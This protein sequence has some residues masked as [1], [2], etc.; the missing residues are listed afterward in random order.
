MDSNDFSTIWTR[1]H[2]ELEA[3]Q[4][5]LCAEIEA[6]WN[7]LHSILQKQV[8]KI[9]GL[10]WDNS[11]EG[12][13]S[14][15]QRLAK[16]QGSTFLLEPLHSLKKSRPLE[17]V[18]SAIDEY[19]SGIEDILRILPNSVAVSRKDRRSCLDWEGKPLR[20]F[21]LR[22]G[23]KSI[24]FNLRAIVSQALLEHS[25]RRAKCDGQ[26]Q[27][28][29]SRTALCL[30]IPWQF[31]RNEELNYLSHNSSTRHVIPDADKEWLRSV[32]AF[33]V[34]GSRRLAAYSRWKEALPGLLA[35]ALIA[36]DRGISTKHSNHLRERWQKHFRF[37][38][39]QQRAIVAQFEM[40]SSCV[41]L[42][43]KATDIS[44]DALASVDEEHTQLLLELDKVSQWLENWPLNHA[45]APFPPPEVRLVSAQDRVGEW[46]RRLE[47][48]GRRAL[49]ISIEAID[50]KR[51]LPGRRTRSRSIAAEIRFIKSL[52]DIGRRIALVGFSEV[53][54]GHR[55]IIREIERAREVVSYSIE[56]GKSESDSE[57]GRQV[58]KDGVANALSL[59]SYQKGIIADYHPEVESR[60]SEALASTFFQ[61]HTRMEENK[62]GLFKLQV[63]QKG[64]NAV[65]AAMETMYANLKNGF[66]WIAEHI[67]K[68]NKGI[69]IKLGWSPPST[70]AL[71][72]VVRRE[73]LGELLRL[74]AGPR[75]L[76]AI[77][78]RLFR[79]AP[80]EDQRF[81][82]GREAEMTAAAQA[83]AFW[84][85]GRSVAI[86]VAGARGSGK[87]SFLNCACSAV[88]SD[89][90]V[91]SGQFR[92]RITTATGMR[93]FLSSFLDVSVADL[94]HLLQSEKRL[95]VLEEV[96]RTFIRR[97]GGFDGL[98]TLLNIISA[99]SKHTLWILSLN[100][101]ALRYLTKIV[102]MEEYFSHR[103]NAM[104]VPPAH[105]RNAILLRH[106]LSGLRL[107]FAEPPVRNS[108]IR[109]IRDLFGLEKDAEQTYFES[110]YRQS[111][112]IFRSAFE[113]WQ[114]SVDRVE[115]GVLYMLSPPNPASEGLMRRLTLEDSFIMKAILQHGSL[116]SDEISLI[117]DYSPERSSSCIE[118][119]V[120][121]EIVEPDP[122]SPGFRVRPEA[123][124]IVR[125]ALYRQNLL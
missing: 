24:S 47:A 52:S 125:E 15:I 23:R 56:V 124:R 119:L 99:T 13:L 82:V 111:E 54:N 62:L 29:L 44:T 2:E 49:P 8:D 110:L 35:S 97:I 4:R 108:G 66:R 20:R 103:I 39:N 87:T 116:T 92:E 105:L 104:A 79:L 70:I 69:L 32:A 106:N 27:L 102:G 18:L 30:I 83:R 7:S 78:K 76:P 63:R 16:T 112:G 3:R 100:E 26:M 28:L 11:P 122:V 90:P 38:A 96:E 37:W 73:Y 19:Q 43:D 58:L 88:F 81:L 109:K 41:Q 40:E 12:K 51:S 107:H 98:R 115:G 14:S 91:V 68:F 57:Q 61:F 75:E 50:L 120:A 10:E 25:T 53:E 95:I 64:L 48:S 42:L 1:F 85:E 89:L 80:V 59:L 55:S 86:L 34:T 113:L 65:R 84:E 71:D 17:R 74:K 118:K 21:L 5:R 117:F 60:L 9:T 93:T 6:S 121:R 31:L 123:G 94:R 114:Q 33:K 77:Y 22:I 72:P 67:S 46:K 36:G 101:V 45:D